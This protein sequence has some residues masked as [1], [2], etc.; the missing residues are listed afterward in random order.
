MKAKT[1]ILLVTI[2]CSLAVMSPANVWIDENFDGTGP[3]S[4]PIWVQGNGGG[5]TVVPADATLDVYVNGGALGGIT[6][7]GSP[8]V[9]TG[10]KVISKFFDGTASYQMTTAQLVSVGRNVCNP[11]NGAFELL[12]V[13]VNFD[14]IPGAGAAGII[15]FNWDTDD[16]AGVPLTP[17]YSFYVK[18]ISTGSQVDIIAGEDL[19]NFSSPPEASI[20]TLTSNTQWKFITF[21]MVNNTPPAATYTHAHLPGGAITQNEGMA[22]YCSST[23]PGHF[24]SMAGNTGNK[25]FEGISITSAATMFIDTLYLEGGLDSDNTAPSINIRDFDYAGTSSVN[26]WALY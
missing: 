12:Q 10:A 7:T 14:P 18:F 13:A 22:F 8:L 5:A 15:R 11:K 26:D 25:H 23:T 2:F 21:V 9:Q 20:G 4:P 3:T 19:K 6:I 16:T 17:D 24:I 1:L